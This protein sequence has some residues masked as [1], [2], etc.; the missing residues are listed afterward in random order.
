MFVALNGDSALSGGLCYHDYLAPPLSTSPTYGD[1]YANGVPDIRNG[2]WADLE[3]FAQPEDFCGDMQA[4]TEAIKTLEAP[5][6]PLQIACA[7]TNQDG[8]VDVSVCTSWN[9][10]TQNRCDVVSDAVPPGAERCSCARVEV[11]PEPGAT[12]A[13]ACSAALLAALV[14]VRVVRGAAPARGRI[15]S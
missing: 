3:P 14:S 1:D 6:L 8:T 13:L 2:P 4:N 9:N 15:G 11:L 10:G 12:V 5:G 7:D